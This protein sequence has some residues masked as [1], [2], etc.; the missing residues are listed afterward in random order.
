MKHILHSYNKIEIGNRLIVF[1]NET[2]IDKIESFENV[3]CFNTTPFEKDLDW[4]K[5][6][7]HLIWKERCLNNPSELFCYE[8]SGDLKWK[9][10]NRNVVGFGKIIPDLKQEKDFI[11]SEHYR[12]YIEK[13]KDKELIEVYAGDFRYLLDVNTGEIYDKMHSK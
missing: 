13:Y 11:T 4:N 1:P 2:N 9:F 5:I 3:I 10:Q 6:E 7:T 12:N 8:S